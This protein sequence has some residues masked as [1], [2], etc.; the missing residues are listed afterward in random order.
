MLQKAVN[1]DKV[2]TH[3]TLSPLSKDRYADTA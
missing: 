1:K 3:I 2:D